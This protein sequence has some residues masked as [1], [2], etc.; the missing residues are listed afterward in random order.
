M[1]FDFDLH[2]YA[3]VYDEILLLPNHILYREGTLRGV[4]RVVKCVILFQ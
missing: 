4:T 1:T 3:N 2:S